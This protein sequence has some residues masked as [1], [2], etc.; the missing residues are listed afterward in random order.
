MLER[1]L[2]IQEVRRRTDGKSWLNLAR[3]LRGQSKMVRLD[4][5]GRVMSEL[6]MTPNDFLTFEPP[7]KWPT[8][9]NLYQR[10]LGGYNANETQA[11]DGHSAQAGESGA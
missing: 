8:S 1:G 11:P 10:V 4:I 6:E 3:L 5:L 2:T 7:K 9:G